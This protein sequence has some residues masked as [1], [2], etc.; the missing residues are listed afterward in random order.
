MAAW[1]GGKF[2]GEWIHVY[3]Q[4]S[5]FSCPPGTIPTLLIVNQLQSNIKLKVFFFFQESPVRILEPQ[6]AGSHGCNLCFFKSGMQ[7]E[8]SAFQGTPDDADVSGSGTPL[9]EQYGPKFIC[10]YYFQVLEVTNH[11]NIN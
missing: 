4:L 6:K 1:M 3:V 10:D 11:P 8:N 5:P 2:G 7:P 9:S